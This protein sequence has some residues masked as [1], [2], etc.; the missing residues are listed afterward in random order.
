MG[1]D[2]PANRGRCDW[3]QVPSSASNPGGSLLQESRADTP[4]MLQ[5]PRTQFEASNQCRPASAKASWVAASNAK[6]AIFTW[7]VRTLRVQLQSHE[8]SGFSHR[9][10]TETS[11]ELAACCHLLCNFH[12]P[13]Q[14]MNSATILF[15]QSRCSCLQARGLK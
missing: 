1:K 10:T 3:I 2:S 5:S 12:L 13:M 7:I 8:S 4:G 9:L 15:H 14:V 11:E 6:P